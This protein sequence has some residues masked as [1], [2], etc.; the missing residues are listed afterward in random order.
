MRFQVPQFIDIED[1]IFGPMTLKQFIY[2]A[3]GIGIT[4]IFFTLLPKFLAFIF[5][6]PFLGISFALAFYKPNN[7]PFIFALES[8]L[9]YYFGDKIYIWKK[10]PKPIKPLETKS[11]T[12]ELI[13]PNLSKSKLK[14]MNW[15]LDV[16][17]HEGDNV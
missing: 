12:P 2:V 11:I 6:A 8:M 13:V 17:K 15:S 9:N 16:R 14:D 4:V 5:A 7:R 3:G 1:K 10:V